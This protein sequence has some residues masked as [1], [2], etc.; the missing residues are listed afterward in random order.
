LWDFNDGAT[1]NERNVDHKFL[2]PGDYFVKLTVNNSYNCSD[3]I[4]KKVHEKPV[5]SYHVPNAFTPNGDGV[6]DKFY[7]YAYNIVE[8]RL[9]IFN[10]YG[11][12]IFESKDLSEGW[13]GSVNGNMVQTETYIYK[14]LLKDIFGVFHEEVGIVN[15]V[16]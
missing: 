10:R 16:K 8:F 1:S 15:C 3:T 12:Q 14:L 2:L 9:L 13:D 6:N 11:E 5:Y 7:V 4:S